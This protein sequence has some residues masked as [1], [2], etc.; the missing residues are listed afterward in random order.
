GSRRSQGRRREDFR[1]DGISFRKSEGSHP[2][3]ISA[4]DVVSTD[5]QYHRIDDDE[6]G[7]LDSHGIENCARAIGFD[8]DDDVGATNV[9][10]RIVDDEQ[11]TAYAL[12]ELEGADWAAAEQR[13]AQDETARRY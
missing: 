1:G 8:T 6:R 10:R 2:P 9:D 5:Q 13:I 3:E 12:G 7:I 4:R 11:L